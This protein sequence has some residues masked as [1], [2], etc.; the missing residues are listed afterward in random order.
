[1][2]AAEAFL[3]RNITDTPVDGAAVVTAQLSG[4][5]QNP[6][7]AANIQAP[8]LQLGQLKAVN[9]QANANYTGTALALKNV[10]LQWQGQT[11][12]ASGTVGLKGRNPA[13][14]L[15]TQTQNLKIESVLAGLNRTDI[16]A[17]G[18]V[19]IDARITG[20][21]KQ[22]VVDANISGSNLV[23]YKEPL[24]TL[25]AQAQVRGDD[26]TI[27]NLTL[28]KP[29]EGGNGKLSGTGTF[30]LET[31]QFTVDAR[32]E[33]IRLTALE[34]PDGR[35]VRGQVDLNAK[36]QGTAD[37]PAGT[38]QLATKDL[39]IGDT[40][41]GELVVASKIANGVAD[42]DAA[43]PA[44]N[45]TADAQIGI[46]APYPATVEVRADKT[47]LESLPVEMK[48]PVKGT[49]S[50]VV[51]AKGN[52]SEYE[53][54]EASAEVSA[55]NLDYNGQPLR[56]EG[57][58][59]AHYANQRLT[60]DRATVLARDSRI[61]VSGTLPLEP[62]AG[63]GEIRL[64]AKL[65]LPTL[66]QYVPE[67]KITAQG[68]ATIDG[69]IRGTLKRID[70]TLSIALNNGYIHSASITPPIS[71]L[72]LQAQVRDGALELQTASASIGPASVSASGTVPFALLPADLPFE[73]PRRQG[74]AQFTAELRDLDLSTI[75]A[76]PSKVDG[77]VSARI[78]ASAPRPE[79]EAVTGKLTLPQLRIQYGTVTLEQQGTTEIA[80]ANGVARVQN[81]ALTG[82]STDLRAT[83]TA[84][85]T[86][87][88][89]LDL[90]VDG[91]T[92]LALMAAFT[93]DMRAEGDAQLHVAVSGTATQPQAAVTCRWRTAAS[94][95]ATR[96][97]GSTT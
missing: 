32:S 40:K 92:D 12:T 46:K 54:G 81:F 82:P 45:L 49:V 70:P 7:I 57:P 6:Q 56:T 20:T 80:L 73:L 21:T 89:P 25:N 91:K 17:S 11:I 94:V 65:D 64:S 29:Q 13:I 15:T 55:L 31:K 19:Q 88:R 87:A 90:R 74:P 37:D 50:A 18:D 68:T 8:E 42:I 93:N 79:L 24:G 3:G 30:N 86:G 10:D 26:V 71:A 38:I 96:A 69:T 52:L 95:C 34:L 39:S 27:A 76:V 84:G 85:L 59:V 33:N 47:D 41:V 48:Q 75:P 83:G 97:S 16:P 23:A 66:V 22:P 2:S 62:A 35:P 9:I 53:K 61:D 43:A 28:D 1:M 60:I 14:D 77:V 72:T 58:L 51:R 4:T 63:E 36:V 44:F 78:E 67:Q 5:V